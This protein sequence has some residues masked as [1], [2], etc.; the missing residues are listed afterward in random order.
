MACPLS[1]ILNAVDGSARPNPVPVTRDEDDD[2]TI[3]ESSTESLDGGLPDEKM[4]DEETLRSNTLTEHRRGASGIE[5]GTVKS[6]SQD[7]VPPAILAPVKACTPF[8]RT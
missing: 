8:V 2:A 7:I 3:S 6:A 4:L 5:S 1:A